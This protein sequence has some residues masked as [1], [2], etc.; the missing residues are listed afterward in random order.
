MIFYITNRKKKTFTF[1]F[2]VSIK[3][4]ENNYFSGSIYNERSTAGRIITLFS[5]V[6][7]LMIF[8]SYSAFITSVLS[9]RMSDIRTLDDIFHYG[10]DI[11]YV[12]E[13]E[14]EIYLQ[15]IWR[16]GTC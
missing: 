3:I 16:K 14:D 10:Y 5:L 2:N 12:A 4:R 6:F 13:S 8:N 9:V 7:A 11:I 1:L 15:V